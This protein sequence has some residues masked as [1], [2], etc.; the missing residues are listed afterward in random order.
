M[1]IIIPISKTLKSESPIVENLRELDRKRAI[2]KAEAYYSGRKG[3]IKKIKKAT[4]TL[5]ILFV[6]VMLSAQVE[7]GIAGG[8]HYSKENTAPMS[9]LSVS[10]QSGPVVIEAAIYN[11]LT[12]NI[13]PGTMFGGTVGYDLGHFI[14]VAG[15][16][17]NLKSNDRKKLNYNIYGGGLRWRKY[18]NENAGITAEAL[19]LSNKNIV[20]SFGLTYQF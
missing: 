11:S 1:A 10:G 5:L 9:K 3:L 18:I 16:F 17:Y 20:A 12:R 7:I 14:P 8:I 13:D 4:A 2:K 6:P 19:Y 15:Y